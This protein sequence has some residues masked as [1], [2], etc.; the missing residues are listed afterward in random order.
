MQGDC[1]A[2]VIQTE[3][4]HHRRDWTGWT[5]MFHS[6][7]ST[8]ESSKV[9]L[10]TLFMG[11]H[12]PLSIR[13]TQKDVRQETLLEAGSIKISL[14]WDCPYSSLHSSQR[15]KLLCPP[16]VIVQVQEDENHTIGYE[17]Q[18]SFC[19]S[20]EPISRVN[21][22]RHFPWSQQKQAHIQNS[23]NSRILQS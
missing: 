1:L 23:S 3:F 13:F 7:V 18:L 12:K 8:R 17:I 9:Q 19:D 10:D 6:A 21:F 4:K 2:R 15:T 20:Q 16:Q 14:Q 22:H 11:Q 5:F